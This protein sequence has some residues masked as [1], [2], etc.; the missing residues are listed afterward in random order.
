MLTQEAR[1]A[2]LQQMAYW[3]TLDD[4]ILMAEALA[5][6]RQQPPELC[7]ELLD[8]ELADQQARSL[9]TIIDIIEQLQLLE[10]GP[11]RIRQELQTRFGVAS[12]ANLSAEQRQEW[13]S[14]LQG[15]SGE[16]RS[17]SDTG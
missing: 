15:L 6:L 5:W 12:I 4:P 1:A 16:A 10:W 2:H 9:S 7:A 14:D 17:H 8:M 3:L 11:K 13:F